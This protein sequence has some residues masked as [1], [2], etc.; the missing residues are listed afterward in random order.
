MDRLPAEIT[1]QIVNELRALE[2]IHIIEDIDDETDNIAKEGSAKENKGM[3]K[4][5]EEKV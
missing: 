4:E 5:N 1:L 3:G 2:G